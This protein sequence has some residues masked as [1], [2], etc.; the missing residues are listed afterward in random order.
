MELAHLHVSRDV[1]S[2]DKQQRLWNVCVSADEQISLLLGRSLT[3]QSANPCQV[4]RK[5]PA[6]EAGAGGG[7]GRAKE[8]SQIP[9]DL[10]SRW[11]TRPQGSSAKQKTANHP[12]MIS[13]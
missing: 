12:H 4:G 10:D 6:R 9:T 7:A 13:P 11:V 2:T 8:P 3:I 5:L 1:S